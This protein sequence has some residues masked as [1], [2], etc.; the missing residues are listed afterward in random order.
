MY[1]IH[2]CL[3]AQ[4]CPAL[5][6]SMAC[7]QLGYSVHGILQARILE[8]VAI[9]FSKGS[10]QL[11][12]WN[13]FSCVSSLGRWI[14]YHHT[15]HGITKS[16]RRLS[17]WACTHIY[18]LVSDSL[19]PHRL[20]PTRLLC[21]SD[22]PGKNNGVDCHFLLHGIFPTQGSNQVSHISGRCFNL[23][24]TREALYI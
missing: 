20:E 2:V 7:S 10:S 18:I 9:S 23:W 4:S 3:V 17:N 5:C 1:T 13:C 8:W 19:R 6:D 16:Q 15:T 21:P 12:D 11:R 14:L 22:S 24:A